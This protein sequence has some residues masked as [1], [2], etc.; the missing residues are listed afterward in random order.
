MSPRISRIY[1]LLLALCLLLPS[2][3]LLDNDLRPESEKQEAAPDTTNY[4]HE[5]TDEYTASYQYSDQTRVLDEQFLSYVAGIDYSLGTLYLEDF[6]PDA[7]L[8]VAGQILAGPI[9]NQLPYGLAHHVVSVTHQNTLYEVRIKQAYIDEVFSHLELEG[10][11]E[12][13]DDTLANDTSSAAPLETRASTP[14]KKDWNFGEFKFNRVIDLSMNFG[15]AL[16]AEGNGKVTT[17]ITF[18]PIIK[19]YIYINQEKKIYDMYVT[20]GSTQTLD[21]RID[22][23][24]TLTLDL[25]ELMGIKEL[26]TFK[27]PLTEIIGLPLWIEVGP[28]F[29]VSG[30][31]GGHFGFNITKTFYNVIGARK[32]VPGKKDGPIINNRDE[33]I[34]FKEHTPDWEGGAEIGMDFSARAAFGVT[35]GIK[36]SASGQEPEAGIKFTLSA[37]PKISTGFD[38]STN[39]YNNHWHFGIPV[40]LD[41]KIYI[42][43]FKGFPPLEVNFMSYL[44]GLWGGDNTLWEFCKKDFRFFPSIDNM[45]IVCV[46]NTESGSVPQFN[47]DFDV[48]ENGTA[49]GE[50]IG[51]RP[52]YR[53]FPHNY[54]TDKPIVEFDPHQYTTFR[55][56]LHFSFPINS[57]LL[58][59]DEIYD[60]EIAMVKPGLPKEDVMYRRK[61]PFTSTSPTAFINDWKKTAQWQHQSQQMRNG[62]YSLYYDYDFVT[63]VHFE[64][65]EQIKE[66]GFI[67]NGE[68]FEIKNPPVKDDVAVKWSIKFSNKSKRDIKLTP[69]I[70]YEL[71]GERYTTNMAPYTVSLNYDKSLN[72]VKNEWE[73]RIHPKKNDNDDYVRSG[74]D[75]NGEVTADVDFQTK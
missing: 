61:F 20:I 48:L 30:T 35:A 37:G 71:D 10:E 1:P 60:L 72:T 67:V 16:Q 40:D 41:G 75:I 53:V 59:R 33:P 9:C 47:V 8:P 51:F 27:L 6:T 56:G 15:E 68:K 13:E 25:L 38:S 28:E 50:K 17:E 11:Y 66:Y 36:L 34:I 39:Y 21:V 22:A 24:G 19:A 57:N 63:Y 2:C 7:L 32:N 14:Y 74:F 44:T 49:T 29:F 70:I 5:Q 23:N 55:Q 31:V 64:R 26:L 69:Y 73:G 12:S 18:K 43:I 4:I 42:D 45:R 65:R 52:I 62:G 54:S 58:Q 3:T 46:N